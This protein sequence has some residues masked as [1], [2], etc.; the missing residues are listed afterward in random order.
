L[1]ISFKDDDRLT[2]FTFRRIYYSWHRGAAFTDPYA[3][4]RVMLILTWVPQPRSHAESRQLSQGITFS[5]RWDMWGH[6]WNDLSKAATAMKQPWATLR[7]LGLY[8][9]PSADWGI[10]YVSGSSM[11]MANEDN[12]FRRHEL[13]DFVHRDGGFKY[14][15]SWL[16]GYVGDDEETSWHEFL[17]DTLVRLERFMTRVSV[18]VAGGYVLLYLLISLVSIRSE[19]KQGMRRVGWALFRL[20]VMVGTVIALYKAGTTHVD[21]TQWASDLRQGLRYTSPFGNEETQYGGPTVFPHRNDVLIETRYKSDFLAMYNDFVSNHPGNRVWNRL[22]DEKVSIFESYSGLPPCFRLAVAEYIVG[23]LHNQA[24]RFL[25]QNN[26]SNFV[27]ISTG[28]AVAQTVSELMAKS[29]FIR[30]KVLTQLDYLIS[31]A[32][33]GHL[34]ESVMSKHYTAPLL[35]KLQSRLL[36]ISSQPKRTTSV[37]IS[38][39]TKPKN[40]RHLFHHLPTATLSAL[41]PKY[42][43]TRRRVTL[44]VGKIHE[45]PFA[46]L[47]AGE[48]VEAKLTIDNAMH[49]YKAVIEDVYSN[50]ELLIVY[51]GSGQRDVTHRLRIYPY[52]APEVG[53]AVEVKVGMHYKNG[54]IHLEK[55]NGLYD[56]EVDG[57]ILEDM[58]D[59]SFRRE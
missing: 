8:K 39:H 20:G 45:S 17:L 51:L 49:W 42:K 38:Q 1:F 3:P 12:G 35:F 36:G 23:A 2:H 43:S 50:G 28:Q 40:P 10:D 31:E 27:E 5:L 30:K 47:R 25:Y 37:T 53:E 59:E 52:F 16:H 19:G 18:G 55:G 7:A 44:S 48:I 6:T 54:T 33:Y 46:Y 21:N 24:A 56:V 11:R 9:D 29:N 15:P 34:R 41:E 26:K 13:V 32:K 58:S 4:D 22:V 14:L 57:N